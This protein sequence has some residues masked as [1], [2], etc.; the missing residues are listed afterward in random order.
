M[1]EFWNLLGFEIRKILTGKVTIFGLLLC[2]LFWFGM[3]MS[4]YIVFSPEEQK[5]FE[6]EQA[7]EGRPL[8]EG[9]IRVVAEE[10]AQ[11]SG[12]SEIG[13]DSPYYHVAGFIRK[14]LG[15]GMNISGIDSTVGT[16]DLSF[17]TIYGTREEIMDYLY[18]YYGLR[19]DER[20]W[21]RE[22]E[23]K[24]TKPF[25]WTANNGVT[26]IKL[27]GASATT[28]MS[29]LTGICLAGVFAKEKRNKTN[30]IILCTAKGRNRLWLVKF[31][32][33]EISSVVIGT[34]ML[35]S[36]VLPH[37][38]FNGLHGI[39]GAWQ[40]VMPFSSRPNTIGHMLLVYCLLYYLICM[41]IGAFAMTLSV[42]FQNSLGVMVTI[43][44]VVITDAFMSIPVKFRALSQIRGLLPL[45]IVSNS[46]GMD[47]RLFSVGD[48][49]FTPLQ[50]ASFIYVIALIFFI[51]IIRGRYNRL[52]A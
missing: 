33:G 21:W 34:V 23:T 14:M 16:D 26:A 51:I 38:I 52:E 27:N 32:A 43:G 9:L 50:V 31:L 17:D 36:V 7:V 39:H 5:V 8:D 47:P 2:A 25:V 44:T 35:L 40:L 45:Q 49:Y 12:L 41:M 48:M 3:T 46:G 42:F 15:Q 37:L 11:K 1:N 13:A 4:G 24:V 30:Q 28:Y 22:R 20:E 10:A 29:I 19:E 6:K 18:D